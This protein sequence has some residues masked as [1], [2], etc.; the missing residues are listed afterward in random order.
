MTRTSTTTRFLQLLGA[1]AVLATAAVLIVRQPS[2]PA[3]PDR[4]GPVTY[5]L[6]GRSGPIFTLSVPAA[7]A[8][9][10]GY[11][12]RVAEQLSG[13]EIKNGASGQISVM[14]W[15][16]GAAVPKDPPATEFDPSM[17]TQIAGIFINPK[18]HIKH[19]IRFRNGETV[20]DR[21]Y[22]SR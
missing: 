15:P 9:D 12:L 2:S 22:G 21:E 11:L 19:L 4:S 13:E 8:Q 14:I 5:T 16:E 7:D 3:R 6:V 17:K 10:D 1:A 20:A 18:L